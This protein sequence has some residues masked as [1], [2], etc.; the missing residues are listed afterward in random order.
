[1]NIERLK[2]QWIPISAVKK[3]SA[4]PKRFMLFD[5]PV[6]I[7]RVKDTIVALQDKCPH[8][9]VALS[10][11]K[12]K[13]DQL[14]CIYHG[15]RFNTQGQCVGIPGLLGE[16]N[17]ADKCVPAYP[18]QEYAGLLFICLKPTEETLALYQ[19]PALAPKHYRAYLMELDIQGDIINVIEN[20]LDATHTHFI[21][22]GLIRNDNKR[23]T[24]SAKLRVNEL[25]AEVLYEDEQKQSGLLSSLF[26][27][28]RGSSI[29]RFHFPLIAELEYRSTT[30]LTAAFSFFLSPK[31]N[32]EHRAF[33]LISYRHH[34]MTSW[35][36]KLLLVP[37]I[38]LAIRQDKSILKQ[39]EMNGRHFPN[40]TY[41]S[42]ELDLL[43][44]HIERILE[45]KGQVY[46]KNIQMKV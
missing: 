39:Q 21:H 24:I 30:S 34:W 10:L 25:C 28:N 32:Q 14:Q 38:K 22:S 45:N 29:G 8:R 23:Q 17:L 5:Q 26:E 7:Y 40:P 1:M 35:L 41:K 36:K 11:G 33:L 9:G 13:D 15:W 27:K 20:T 18:T 31:Q 37:F 3:I 4:K 2:Q 42:T 19:I 12:I 46:Q 16:T 6:V 43:R 44:P